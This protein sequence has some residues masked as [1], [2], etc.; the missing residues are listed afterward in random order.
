MKPFIKWAGGK[1]QL[2]KE[3]QNNLP[4]TYNNYYEPFL[5]G[6]AVLLYL[7]PKYAYVNDLNNELINTYKQVKNNSKG[8][9]ILLEN[10]KKNHSKEYYYSMRNLDRNSE[11]YNQLSDVEKAARFIYLNKTC[12]NGMY[13][14]NKKNQFNVPIGSYKNPTIYNQELIKDISCYLNENQVNFYNYD[15]ERFLKLPQQGDFVYLDPPYD[16]VSVTSSFTSYQVNG[17]TKD[18][19]IRLKC[20]CD[21]LNNRNVKFMLSNSDTSFINDLYKNYKI[22]K[23]KAKRNIN[24]KADKRSPIN[25]VII[26]NY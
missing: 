13:R 4:D 21:Q 24:S 2:L 16:P 12:Y 8:L 14:V 1:T 19:Q 23:V 22:I 6:G 17:F 7:K 15:F 5:G 18:D 26:M 25:E 20:A 11:L 3:I 10:H 9:L